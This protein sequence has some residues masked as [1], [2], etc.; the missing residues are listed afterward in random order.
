MSPVEFLEARLARLTL[1]PRLR[2]HAYGEIRSGAD[3]FPLRAFSWGAEGLPAVMVFGGVHGDEPCG[4]E[5]CARLLERLAEGYA[6]LTGHQFLIFPCVNPSGLADGTRSNRAGQDVNR[7]FHAD[8][9][10]ETTAVR[11]FL[12]PMPPDVVI[13]L[14]TDAQAQGFY[15]F[16]LKRGG[17]GALAVPVLEALTAAGVALED[18]PYYAGHVGECGLLAPTAAVLE[19]FH[20]RAPGL[21]LTDWAWSLGVHRSYCFE[22]AFSGDVGRGA[23]T[24]L[25]A[26]TALFAA[27]EDGPARAA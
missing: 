3:V 8:A 7:Q 5:A 16:E 6:P 14:H 18:A 23:A 21:A 25:T 10:A 20:R 19:E 2:A 26:L 4:V 22:V 13:D 1:S 12:R 9:T 11:R 27:L 17:V 24:H 15:L